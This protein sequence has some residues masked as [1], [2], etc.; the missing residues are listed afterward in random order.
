MSQEAPELNLFTMHKTPYGWPFQQLGIP[1]AHK[2]TRGSPDV[3]VA[4]I[5]LGYVQHP[6][7]EG[8][9]WINP[10]PTKGDLHG[11]DCFDDDASLEPTGPGQD[12]DYN[13]RHHA[14]VAGEVMA[15][16][17][18][19]KVMIVRVGYGKPDSWWQ[20]IDYAVEHGAKVL[21]IPHGFISY[22]KTSA[23]SP[24]FYRGTD[25]GYPVDN[26]QIRRALDD[27]YDA[28]CLTCRGTADNRGRRVATANSGFASVISIGSSN[29][30]GRAADIVAEANYVEVGAPGGQRGTNNEVD[31]VW[32][33]GGDNDYVS[34]SGGCMASGFG[35]G[36][37]ALV[38]SRFPELS[39][40]QIRQ[41]LRN[42]AGNDKW[43]NKLGW[44]ILN[45]ARAVNLKPNALKQ[46]LQIE[47]SSAALRR[48][49]GKPVL[50]IS[51]H[52]RGAFDV[53]QALLVAFNGDP[54][55]AAAPRATMAKPQILITRQIGHAIAPVRGLHSTEFAI[56]LTEA[57][58]KRIWLQLCTLDR[59]GSDQVHTVKIPT[60]RKRRT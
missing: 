18:E 40:E 50:Q 46:E 34:S 47:L 29:R 24:L 32:S 54:L 35:G 2:V 58:P 12:N 6:D 36:V 52:N 25:F 48:A 16:A 1:K 5:D 20:G 49:R 39:N 37:A 3:V 4:V 60:L 28:G 42:T 55:K 27:A 31:R 15:C 8:H 10:K 19:C 13:R 59:H 43:D 41:I 7:H 30:H 33:T 21:V 44:G 57:P 51:V 53:D 23:R 56:K 9:L 38:C 11:W 45:A 22:G 17:P 14:F 26:P